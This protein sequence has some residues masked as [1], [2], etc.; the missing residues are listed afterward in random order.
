MRSANL[1]ESKDVAPRRQVSNP[2]DP[3][4]TDHLLVQVTDIMDCC[5]DHLDHRLILVE[6]DGRHGTDKSCNLWWFATA[7]NINGCAIA[8][9]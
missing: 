2:A 6:R 7:G 8:Q 4:A 9:R 5:T 3:L 1:L